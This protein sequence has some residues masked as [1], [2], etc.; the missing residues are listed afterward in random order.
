MNNKSYWH[1]LLPLY[2]RGDLSPQ[3]SLAL[4]QRLAH[5]PELQAALFEWQVLADVVKNTSREWAADPPPLS[6]EFKARL[7]PQ[8]GQSTQPNR[9]QQQGIEAEPTITH[10]ATPA[11]PTSIRHFPH[12]D[13]T[14]ASPAQQHATLD[15]AQPTAERT[16]DAGSL[17]H[18]D[19]TRSLLRLPLSTLAA[20]IV[21]L[22]VV[23]FLLVTVLGGGE[24]D[25][26]QQ[27]NS[28]RTP[29]VNG[30]DP[31]AAAIPLPGASITPSPT[32][33]RV[34]PGTSSTAATQ[35]TDFFEDESIGSG[36][37]SG[38]GT[39]GGIPER[40]PI[41]AVAASATH[42]PRPLDA[43][44]PAGS[45][46]QLTTP[47]IVSSALGDI[48]HAVNPAQADNAMPVI[49]FDAPVNSDDSELERGIEPGETWWVKTRLPETDWF[50]VV[51]PDGS[52]I[53]GWVP[54]S[55]I[56]L[57]G[58]CNSIVAPTPTLS[59]ETA[60]CTAVGGST[61]YPEAVAIYGLPDDTSPPIQQFEN[62]TVIG[63]FEDGNWLRV[64]GI[65]AQTSSAFMGFVLRTEVSLYGNCGNLAVV[66][67]DNMFSM[68]GVVF[69]TPVLTPANMLPSD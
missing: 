21:M 34:Q 28:Q 13:T 35:P 6:I 50:E 29:T 67:E 30:F 69:P 47:E 25:N 23:G 16:H 27:S 17:G 20:A 1:E 54:A 61:E 41:P 10:T 22:F 38:V 48:C 11:Q 12:A 31:A 64:V 60:S 45:P 19:N 57:N 53:S 62:M 15:T 26:N 51:A 43:G 56:V 59:P 24:N 33:S 39:G 18:I 37:A 8:N 5:D 55:N 58:N 66:T 2:V 7:R 52:G 68:E 42:T 49:V 65:S 46:E 14:Q 44:I 36:G 40:N 32:I 9:T 4:E 3:Q 63:R